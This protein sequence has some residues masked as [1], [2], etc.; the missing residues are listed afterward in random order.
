MGGGGTAQHNGKHNCFWNQLPLV[1]FPVFPYKNSTK[2]IAD[3]TEVN[4]KRSLEESREWFETVDQTHLVL[5]SGK[6]I[7]Q[8]DVTELK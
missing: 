8:K 2:K 6:Q 4:Q 1:R 5:A 3:V 7:L